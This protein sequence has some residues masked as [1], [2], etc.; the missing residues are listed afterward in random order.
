M[1]TTPLLVMSAPSGA[2]KTSIS[3]E[4]EQRGLGKVSI[5]FTTRARRTSERDGIDYKF[6]TQERFAHLRDTGSL[7][8]HA[9][10]HGHHYGTER[11]WVERQLIQGQP[12][13]LVIDIA[14]AA[15]IKKAKAAAQSLFILPPSLAVLEQRLR[16]RGEHDELI[17][18]R[19]G[20]ARRELALMDNFDYLMVNDKLDNAID[21]A[22]A[23][24]AACAGNPSPEATALER[25]NQGALIATWQELLANSP[26]IV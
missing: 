7:L 6:I 17:R 11:L 16:I 14:G 19:L 24:I 9:L 8:E 26:N 2:G 22:A 20:T 3:T 10:V 23:V 21:Q 4:L 15:Q 18:I 12:I 25:A 13:L 1:P 5:S